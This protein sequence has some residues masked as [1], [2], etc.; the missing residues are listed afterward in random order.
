[1]DDEQTLLGEWFAARDAYDD[2]LQQ[3]F[4]PNGDP[5][6]RRPDQGIVDEAARLRELEE[7]ARR[8]YDAGRGL[9]G[10]G[11]AES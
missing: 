5:A 6:P 7:A 10:F 8:R 3:L 4:A 2:L 9:D 11:S 1:M